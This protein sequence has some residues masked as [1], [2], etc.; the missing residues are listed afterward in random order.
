M[1]TIRLPLIAGA[2]LCAVQCGCNSTSKVKAPP[3]PV[4]VEGTISQFGHYVGM[5]QRSVQGY[6]VV[7]RLGEN[8]SSEVPGKI[9]DYLIQYLHKHKLGFWRH[10]T[11]DLH[12]KLILRDLDTAVV[13]VVGDVPHGAPEGS[14]F[15]LQIAALDSSNT[16][17]LAGGVLMPTE[18]RLAIWGLAVPGGPTHVWAGGHGQVYISP[19][20]DH[21]KP[22][23]QA[24]LRRGR[25]IGGG[26]VT[27]YR[28]VRLVLKAPS[29]RLA[30]QIEGRIKQRFGQRG[31]R[32]RVASAKNDETIEISVPRRYAHNYKHFL[33]LL[34]HLPLARNAAVNELRAKD[35]LDA[36]AQP[37]ARY[38]QLALSLE[39]I[40]GEILPMIQ[41][42]YGS[43]EPYVAFYAARTG[44]R[45]GDKTAR[46]I[47]LRTARTAD[48]PLQIR[49]IRELALHP[50]I[51]KAIE[52][53]RSL[54]DDEN[55]LVRLAAYE[56]LVKHGDGIKIKRT[57]VGR[58]FTLDVIDS[59]GK[60]VIYATQT[61]R[62]LIAIFGKDL[63]VSNPVFFSPPDELVTISDT[64]RDEA[65]R[66]MVDRKLPR[67]SM[68]PGS[69]NRSD[70]LYIDFKTTDL[71]RTLGGRA[72]RGQDRTITGL[73]LTYSQVLRV[74][75][76]LCDSTSGGID[77]RFELQAI[78][79]SS[80]MYDES[81]MG[82]RPD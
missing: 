14:R 12:P 78:A 35:I 28:P 34:L 64:R 20:L 59:K 3:V 1:S 65:T 11:A 10:D 63:P 47:V 37:E 7:I 61:D 54:L 24:E 40:G 25:I 50:D 32:R 39:A 23:M 48:S 56:A 46:A 76:G 81:W 77:A 43:D 33:E 5:V 68:L 22:A 15:D 31:D 26:Q 2:L 8:G 29:F 80:T 6:G 44:L 71:I 16:R 66:L 75:R 9:R 45:L 55:W 17:S 58:E 70:M 21:T 69:P 36:M 82:I 57:I 13:L 18:L 51:P 27:K 74:L 72:E 79:E 67:S 49:A 52:S 30:R 19:V 42:Y 73:A 38:E 53:L 4:Y 62:P 41:P 60:A